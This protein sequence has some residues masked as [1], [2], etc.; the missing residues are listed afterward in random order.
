MFNQLE[1]LLK[2]PRLYEVTEFV[3]WQEDY[4][5]KQL[6]DIH[7]DVNDDLAS[8]KPAFLDRSVEWIR[9]VVPPD[10]YPRLLD[11][12]CGPGLY[13]ERF[14]KTGYAVTGIDFSKRTIDYARKHAEEQNLP[15][16][17]ICE[18]YLDMTLRESFDFAA[19]IYCDYGALSAAGRRKIMDHAYRRLRAGGRFLLDVCSLRQYESTEENR[20]W[21]V[22]DGGFWSGERHYCLNTVKKYEQNTVLNQT[23]VVTKNGSKVYNIWNHC[24]SESDLVKEA[25]DSGFHAVETFGDVTG[26]PYSDESMTIAVLLEK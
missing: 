16:R 26:Q 23:V 6:L 8:R 20:S 4:I 1:K 14:V 10:R 3:F 5:S 19:L 2:L 17:Y 25:N 11:I 12:G 13:A 7:L 24:F 9:S 22:Q 18:N 15:I 21:S